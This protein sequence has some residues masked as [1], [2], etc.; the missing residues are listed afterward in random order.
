MSWTTKS[1]EKINVEDMKSDHV[2]KVLKMLITQ[3]TSFCINRGARYSPQ[4]K[5]NEMSEKEK[6]KLLTETCNDRNFLKLKIARECFGP[7]EYDEILK[8]I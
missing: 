7:K 6:R 8:L 2:E 5:L 3:Y 4:I 1:G